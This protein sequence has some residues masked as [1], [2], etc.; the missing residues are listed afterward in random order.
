MWGRLSVAGAPRG[1]RGVGKDGA[2]GVGVVL[3][4]LAAFW[5]ADRL[6]AAARRR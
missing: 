2:A 5:A 1:G 6:L 4:F 3:A